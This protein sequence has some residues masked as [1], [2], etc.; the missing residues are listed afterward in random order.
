MMFRDR[1]EAGRRLA[2]AV[3]KLGVERPI[4]LG[5]PRGGVPVAA[6]VARATGGD[7]A[8]IVARKLGAPGNPEL[9]I[10]ATTAEGAYYLDLETARMVGANDAY[11]AQERER[12]AREAARREVLFDSHRRPPMKDRIVIV[13][14]DGVATGSTAIAS[15]R[16]VKAAGAAR[17][18]L[19][20]PV[21][22]PHTIEELSREADE[23][24]CLYIDPGFWAVGQYYDRF[25]QVQD[26]E[27]IRIL[28]SFVPV[29][30]GDPSRTFSVQRAAIRLA[31]RLATPPGVGPF[32]AVV[33]VHGLGSSKESPRNVVIAEALVD[34]GLAAV[35]FDLSGHGESDTDTREGN[36][37]YA[38]DL[39]A[40]FNWAE[41][42]PELDRERL[43]VAGSSLGAVISM[44]AAIEGRIRPRTMV[45]RAPPAESGQFAGL[46][47]P[48]LVL[49][50]SNDPLLSQVKDGAAR[51]AGA[52][53]SVVEG[54]GHLFEEPGALE[55]AVERT[56]QWFR[57]MLLP[58]KVPEPSASHKPRSA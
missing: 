53:L 47:T 32:P 17:V 50:G 46:E 24:I 56:V 22:P 36:Q 14:D 57:R 4:V 5:I 7:L 44:Q 29:A 40:V 26:E 43:A 6:E 35:L 23:V 27:V 42:Q 13:V 38:D 25:E 11:I 28:R 3:K 37:A 48:C 2:E 54:A 30:A 31:G 52:R 45:L 21:G 55:E 15:V 8:V 41:Q 34:A 58:E 16:S 9:A 1:T 39:Q 19:A 10:G 18:I 12:Q 20:V 51:S 49:V 33:F